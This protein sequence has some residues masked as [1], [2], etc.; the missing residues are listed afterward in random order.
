MKNKSKNLLILE[1]GFEIPY[2]KNHYTYP[3]TKGNNCEKYIKEISNFSNDSLE[4]LTKE[5][6]EEAQEII[7]KAEEAL[8]NWKEF[9][10]F[11]SNEII[12]VRDLEKELEKLEH[13]T[14]FDLHFQLSRSYKQVSRV[15][16]LFDDL[17]I[18]CHT[19]KELLDCFKKI[20]NLYKVLNQTLENGLGKNVGNLIVKRKEDTVRNTGE[21][22]ECTGQSTSVGEYQT[23]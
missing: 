6:V 4:K 20:E 11:E 18:V 16:D 15:F 17:F 13:M 14:V 2:F 8:Q 1:N 5:N 22:N 3:A 9:E 19:H 21:T 7:T 23:T 10:D 12:E